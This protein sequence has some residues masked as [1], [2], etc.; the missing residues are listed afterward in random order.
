MLCRR[1]YIRD[2]TGRVL[3]STDPEVRKL[4][5]PFPCGQ[6]LACRINKRRVWTLRLLLESYLHPCASFVTLT[7][8][9]DELPYSLDGQPILCKR[10]V[11]L[12]LKRLRDDFCRRDGFSG[13]QIRY[14][15]A[16]EYGPQ[17]HLPH[18]HGILFG[19]YPHQLDDQ[20]MYYA[21][22]SGPYKPNYCRASRLYSLWQH[23]IVHVGECTRDSI[24]YCAGYVLKKL[25]RKG[26]GL[27][28]EFALMSRRP[29]L[30]A[31]AVA[32]IS[33]VMQDVPRDSLRAG[34]GKTLRIEGKEYALGRY[35]LDKL[36]RVSDVD[37]SL[38]DY[39]ESLRQSFRES[40]R[41]GVP[42]LDFLVESDAQKYLNL[43]SKQQLFDRRSDL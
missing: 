26:D 19:V 35:L 33:R 18:Y 30:G 10:D 6:C 22:R 24:R 4:G 37:T 40:K 23:G 11:Q 41:Q 13:G 20:W 32:A 15:F 5:I 36:R 28:P 42:Y 7:Y 34:A 17:G 25:T 2:P 1:P 21:G 9:P 3:V 12:F 16:G 31:R 39:E 27:V 14:Y 38:D 43:E 8:A 29:G